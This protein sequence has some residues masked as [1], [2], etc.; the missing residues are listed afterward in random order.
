[1]EY[2]L[3]LQSLLCASWNLSVEVLGMAKEWLK[4]GKCEYVFN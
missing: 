4:S 1:M 2:L 3:M